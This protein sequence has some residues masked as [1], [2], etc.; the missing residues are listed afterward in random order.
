MGPEVVDDSLAAA[1]A[2]P[3]ARR[4]VIDLVANVEASAA[5]DQE[6]NHVLAPGQGCLVEGGGMS[7]VALWVVA[8]GVFAG[9]EQE[10]CDVPVTELGG[11]GQGAMTVLR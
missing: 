1:M 4:A 2:G 8:V 7:V 3:A 5:F 6:A 10:F 9:I 11:E